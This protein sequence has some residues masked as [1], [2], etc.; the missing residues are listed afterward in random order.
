MQEHHYY[1]QPQRPPGV[2]ART[3]TFFAM[4]AAAAMFAGVCALTINAF[5]ESDGDTAAGQRI[6]FY[7]Y[8]GGV[9]AGGY[10]VV[11]YF[12]EAAAT[13]GIAAHRAEWGGEVWHFASSENLDKFLRDPPR[14]IPQYGGHCAYGV[15]SGYLVR[16]D[17]RAWSIREDKLYLN[18]SANIRL[19]WIAAADEFIA[20]AV[21]NWK[22]LNR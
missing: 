22:K 5:S 13:K 4:F 15:A 8:P 9:G 16:G 3:L 12:S 19:A 17:P 2:A 20:D 1:H 21:P 7:E 11:A 6:K 10:D 14:Y 18:Y